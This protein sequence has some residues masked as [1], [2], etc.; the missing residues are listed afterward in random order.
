MRDSLL[1]VAS[2]FF[3]VANEKDLY[4]NAE[5]ILNEHPIL[6]PSGNT[7][8]PDKVIVRN[9]DVVVL[10]FKTGKKEVKDHKQVKE[11]KRNLEEIFKKKVVSMLYYSKTKELILA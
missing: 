10:D 6:L 1:E 2:C 11:Y 5:K 4:K 3:D 8:R 9:L 7:L